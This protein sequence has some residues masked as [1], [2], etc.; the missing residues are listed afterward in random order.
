M[1]LGKDFLHIVNAHFS[2]IEGDG[3]LV[4]PYVGFHF[5]HT[6]QPYKDIPYPL[7][8]GLS[9]APGI[10]KPY[11]PFGRKRRLTQSRQSKQTCQDYD[12]EE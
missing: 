6:V 9:G 7:S 12:P 4:P 2:V 10:V 1:L 3:Y 5:F 11:N 8:G